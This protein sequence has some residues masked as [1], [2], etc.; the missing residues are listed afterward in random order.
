[1]CSPLLSAGFCREIINKVNDPIKDIIEE[2]DVTE[3]LLDSLYA[4][5]RFDVEFNE[6]RMILMFCF[7]SDSWFV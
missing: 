5:V 3:D 6:V 1:M 2:Q 7:C 4:A